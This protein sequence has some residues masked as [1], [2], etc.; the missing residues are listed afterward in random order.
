VRG[1]AVEAW[2]TSGGLGRSSQA[3]PY[4]FYLLRTKEAYNESVFHK[5]EEE[6]IRRVEYGLRGQAAQLG[7]QVIPTKKLLMFLASRHGARNRTGASP[8]T[9]RISEAAKNAHPRPVLIIY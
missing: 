3:C 5:S 7:F 6:T 4:R 9:C 8:A 1:R 2:Q